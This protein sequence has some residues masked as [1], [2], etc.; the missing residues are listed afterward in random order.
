MRKLVAVFMLLW[1][2]LSGGNALAASLAMQL[3]QGECHPAAATM[4]HEGMADHGMMMDHEMPSHDH[5]AMQA[6]D[7]TSN[8]TSCGVCHLACTAYLDAPA[9]ALPLAETVSSAVAAAAA[10]FVSHTS[11]PL[12]P[13]P[14]VAA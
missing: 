3:Q 14:L 12:L 8:C 4:S 2:P 9:V 13:P 7:E 10:H 5:T 1:L 11:A 6:D